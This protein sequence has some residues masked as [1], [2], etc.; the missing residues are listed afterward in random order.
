MSRNNIDFVA[1]LRFVEILDTEDLIVLEKRF[2]NINTVKMVS[3]WS[4]SEHTAIENK[5][6]K[7]ENFAT[8]TC[9]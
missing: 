9:R 3:F 5:P 1:K 8:V 7:N 4:I 6:K 2:I